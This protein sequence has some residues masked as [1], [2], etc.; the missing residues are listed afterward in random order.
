[1]NIKIFNYFNINVFQMN[2]PICFNQFPTEEMMITQCAHQFCQECLQEWLSSH[3]TCPICRFQLQEDE[4]IET[5]HQNI[6]LEIMNQ[7]IIIH[8]LNTQLNLNIIED[9]LYLSIIHNNL[10]EFRDLLLFIFEN[11]LFNIDHL[12]NIINNTNINNSNIYY[13]I[14]NDYIN[15][16]Y[17]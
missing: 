13:S 17:N 9:D 10:D 15:I 3:D 11:N 6:N 8:N 14:V 5:N 4:I 1:M 16:F 2:C 7:N 12:F